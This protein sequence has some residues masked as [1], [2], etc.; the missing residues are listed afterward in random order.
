MTREEIQ[1]GIIEFLK[2]H[3]AKKIALFGSFARGEE[4]RKSDIDV[5]V[6]FE[7]GVTYF[8]LA[9]MQEELTE[10]LGR[11]VDLVTDVDLNPKFFRAISNDLH[12][13]YQ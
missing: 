6:E 7:G 12:V 2:R 8:K 1:T 4:T 5:L 9:S 3:N 13:I 10:R 11:N